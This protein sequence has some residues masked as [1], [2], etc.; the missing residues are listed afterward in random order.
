[1]ADLPALSDSTKR[2]LAVQWDTIRDKQKLTDEDLAGYDR[3]RQKLLSIATKWSRNDRRHRD[4]RFATQRARWIGESASV[5]AAEARF[6]GIDWDYWQHWCHSGAQYEAYAVWLD[7]L[8]RDTVAE[9]ASIWN[10]KSD[11]TDRWFAGTCAPAIEKA[12]AALVKQRIAQARDVESKRLERVPPGN[13]ILDEIL[14]GGENLSLPAQ[15]ATRLAWAQMGKPEGAASIVGK[16]PKDALVRMEAATAAFLAEY[17]PKLEREA[18]KSGPVHDAELLREFVVHQFSVVARECMAVCVSV[19]EFEAELLS[20]IAR[21][22]H[23]GLSQYRWLA[24]PMLK[25]LDTGFMFFVLRNNPWAKIPDNERASAWHVGATTGEALAHAALKL[26]A[27]AWARAA[28]GCFPN[29]TQAGVTHAGVDESTRT[30]AGL[31]VNGTNP[32]E[33]DGK[34]RKRG[35]KSD[36]EAASRVAE[37]VAR[38][39]PDGDWRPKL[40]DICEALDEAEIPYPRRWRKR[41]RSCDGWAAYDQRANAVKAIEYR[42][43]IAKQRKKI[44]PRTLS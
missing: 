39:A 13:P 8:K 21:F 4:P 23:Y 12:L 27:E 28:E 14:A 9:L 37:I 34:R 42:L 33:S 35:P 17:L 29:L 6:R 11:V 40:D 32:A 3:E 5:R 1:M 41:D 7:S 15:K 10:G 25:E 24:E 31:T 16:L 36:H 2:K 20:D 43:E 44:T 22:V 19:E 38:V 18:N 30:G 26:R